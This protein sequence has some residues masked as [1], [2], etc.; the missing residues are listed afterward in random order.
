MRMKRLLA[1]G[2]A[3]GMMIST[4]ACGSSAAG[5]TGTAAG[6]TGATES[7]T[8][9]TSATTAASD[10]KITHLVMA[11]PTFT[12]APAD[13]AKVQDAMNEILRKK[14]GVEVELQ[15]SDLASYKQNMT[16]ALSSG[17]QIDIMNTIM[18]D[19]A[20]LIA[21][22]SLTNLE[23]DNLMQTDGPG[24]VST[25]GQ[26]YVDA[27]RVDGKLY[28]LPGMRDYAQG[29]GCIAVGTEYLDAIG[30]KEPE[31]SGE[32]VKITE[33]E[34]NDIL[35]KLHKQFPDMEVMRPATSGVSQYTN[36]DFL[37]GNIFG[38]LENYGQDLKVVDAFQTD[39]YKNFCKLMYSWNQNGYIS[40]DA[41][42]DTTSVGTLEAAGTLIAYQ[43]GGK[44]G[45]KAQESS[46][47]NRDM[48]IFQTKDD[49][50]SSSSV[51]SFMWTIPSTTVDATA[52]MKLMNELYTDP[53]IENLLI[54]GI[55]DTNYMVKDGLAETIK[56]ES[57][58]AAY[59]TLGWMAPNQFLSY[60][61]SG[62]SA[63]LWDQI[64]SFNDNAK[65]SS[66]LGF[67]FD[68][69]G[70]TTELAAVQAVYDEYQKTLEYGFADP[71]TTIAEMDKKMMDAGLQKIIDAKQE[72]L[73]AWAAA[74]QSN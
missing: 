44:P 24:I 71:D 55:K 69:T 45:S 32:I 34:L 30:Y 62:N 13:T 47:G 60:V 23:A 12:G 68:G 54:Y 3:A 58:T 46:G 35:A 61:G 41:T 7:G 5:T 19:Y 73:D 53:E 2:M 57:G 17:E 21:Q 52:A 36:L 26:D 59:S 33:D 37:G 49:Y 65:K 43:T 70:V 4:A 1:I 25:I 9:D 14:I 28:A 64:K 74:K 18:Q 8:T 66:A 63:D 67:S 15:I 48:T 72:Q 51:A 29:K 27:C 42:T 38:V 50:M 22:G 39:E 56:D 11:F 31:G 16:L 40:K 20:T 10:G 6:T